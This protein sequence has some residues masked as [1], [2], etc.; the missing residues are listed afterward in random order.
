L[1]EE[2]TDEK[3]KEVEIDKDILVKIIVEKQA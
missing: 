2:L 3:A 1:V